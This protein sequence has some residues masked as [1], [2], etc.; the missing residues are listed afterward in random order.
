L[1][2]DLTSSA[3]NQPVSVFPQEQT[4]Q[5]SSGTYMKGQFIRNSDPAA[6]AV[7]GW[8]RLTTGSTHVAGTDWKAIALT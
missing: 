5:P 1:D 3:Y 4:A 2:Q 8:L 6:T 7:F